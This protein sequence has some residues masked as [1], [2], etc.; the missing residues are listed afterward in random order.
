MEAKKLALTSKNC[1]VT[2]IKRNTYAY[3]YTENCKDG[4]QLDLQGY[5]C[6]DKKNE[7]APKA[8]KDEEWRAIQKLYSCFL[9]IYI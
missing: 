7:A 8:I 1:K 5:L 6:I 2:L 4:R 9:R 3:K